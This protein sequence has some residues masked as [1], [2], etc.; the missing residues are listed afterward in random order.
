[1]NMLKK[2]RVIVLIFFLL[3][4]LVAINPQ[5]NTEGVVI[6]SVHE[7]SEADLAGVNNPSKDIAPT[8]YEKIERVN[9]E[10]I[11]NLEEYSQLLQEV[12]LDEQVRLDTSLST[13]TII[14]NSND[15]GLSIQ[16]IPQ[17]NIIL[18]L[19]LQGGTRVLLKPTEQITDEQRDNLIEVMKARL[20]TYG[21][22]DI[23]IR[24]SDDLLPS[25]TAFHCS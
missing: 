9:G 5:F 21:L 16:N 13:Y 11:I 2:A 17:S 22:S 3:A 15:L 19:D 4:T 24:S 6:K 12:Q 25:Y 10:K 20:N 14:K 23:E 1:M 8:N 18:G 7:N